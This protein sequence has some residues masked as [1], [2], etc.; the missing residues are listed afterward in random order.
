MK[1]ITGQK[2]KGKKTSVSPKNQYGLCW[3]CPTVAKVKMNSLW[4][5]VLGETGSLEWSRDMQKGG[6]RA[7][8]LW[9]QEG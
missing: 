8:A 2:K 1:K 6:D 5:P 7:F 3:P 9:A 4:F